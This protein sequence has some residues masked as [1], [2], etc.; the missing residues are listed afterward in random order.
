MWKLS[1]DKDEANKQRSAK[2]KPATDNRQ[3]TADISTAMTMTTYKNKHT[4]TP[5]I[6]HTHT[7][8][9]HLIQDSMLTVPV[10]VQPTLSLILFALPPSPAPHNRICSSS[11]SRCMLLPSARQRCQSIVSN[12]VAFVVVVVAAANTMTLLMLVSEGQSDNGTADQPD[13]L[14]KS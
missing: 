3:Q 9:L 2:D 12:K 7:F 14:T 5:N 10:A 6:T 11:S 13:T 1:V 4:H 8:R